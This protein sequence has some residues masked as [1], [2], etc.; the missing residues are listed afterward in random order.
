MFKATSVCVFWHRHKMYHIVGYAYRWINYLIIYCIY[1]RFQ[2][3][4]WPAG[5]RVPEFP[6]LHILLR[7]FVWQH[8]DQDILWA[9]GMRCLTCLSYQNLRFKQNA[10]HPNC[11]KILWSLPGLRRTRLFQLQVSW[12]W[13]LQQRTWTV[14]IRQPRGTSLFEGFSVGENP[15]EAPAT[16]N[17]NS[18]Y[19]ICLFKQRANTHCKLGHTC[20]WK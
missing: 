19:Q 5:C 18:A 3:C 9:W 12:D 17:P 13:L 20:C 11:W 4:N 15:S 14:L 6:V 7:V 1:N 10:W 8:V 2:F 16:A